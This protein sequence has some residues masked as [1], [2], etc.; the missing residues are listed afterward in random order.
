M[1]LLGSLV[2]NLPNKAF[3][4]GTPEDYGLRYEEAKFFTGS[5]CV[6]TQ[7]IT[8]NPDSQQPYDK[9]GRIVALVYCK[10]KKLN[11]ELLY[12]DLAAI[13]KRFWNTLANLLMSLGLRIMA[14][15]RKKRL[16]LLQIFQIIALLPIAYYCLNYSCLF[17]R[18]FRIKFK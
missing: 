12:S 6:L 1:L 5:L 7:E 17:N 15:A 18:N 9:Y 4:C 8:V 16:E 14:V 10:G 11:A 3:S 13:D 2:K